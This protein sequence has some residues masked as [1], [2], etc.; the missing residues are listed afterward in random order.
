MNLL[1]RLAAI[2]LALQPAIAFAWPTWSVSDGPKGSF[3]TDVGSDCEDLSAEPITYG[4]LYEIEGTGLPGGAIDIHDIWLSG[5]CVGCHNVTAMGGLRLDQPANAGYEL[6]SAVS[7]RNASIL[8][9][10][11]SEPENSLLYTMLNCTPPDTYPRMPPVVD[12]N[13]QRIPRPL[14]ARVYDWI[15]QGARGFDED[16]NP[17]SDVLFRDNLESLRHQRILAEPPPAPA[18]AGR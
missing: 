1:I 10:Q 13:S 18:P 4:M 6:I 12:V 11:P 8:L 17:Y 2:T 14:R 16:G 3:Q 7:F 5:G 9:V 15:A